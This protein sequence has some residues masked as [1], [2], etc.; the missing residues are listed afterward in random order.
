MASTVNKLK[1]TGQEPVKKNKPKPVP[2]NIEKIMSEE[3]K[4]QKNTKSQPVDDFM[5]LGDLDF[6]DHYADEKIDDKSLLL[7]ENTAPT[8]LNCGFVG[9]GGGGGKIAK[10][11]LDL[12]YNRAILVNTTAK[13]QPDEVDPDHFLLLD[14][15]D[16]VGKDVKVGEQ[17]LF[18]N[19]TLVEDTL[20]SRLGK[21]D[22]LFVC[23]SG[24]G[25]TGSSAVSLSNTFERYLSS[26]QATGKVVFIVTKPTSQELLNPTI[27]QNYNHLLEGIKSH[28]Y[29]LIDNERQLELLRGKVGMLGMYPL[30]NQAFSRMVAQVFKMASESSPIQSFDTQDLERCLSS[31]GRLF[32]GSSA[33]REF[34][35]DK[36]GLKIYQGCVERSPCPPP[37]GKP[38][39]GS[40]LLIAS[41]D[42]A[43]DPGASN[44]ME[45]AIS[46]VGGRAKTQ[47][48]GVYVRNG[49]TGLVSICLMGG[50]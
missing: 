35:D 1:A 27:S 36:L 30:A 17:V 15:S 49:V 19:C 21:V 25:G 28:P 13:D 50:M 43:N 41:P 2:A 11:F 32:L 34:K 24:G 39:V 22:W 16:G 40:L 18:E 47:F 42:T 31:P 14:G 37:S 4:E 33:V 23:A 48:S 38:E 44:Q 45:S 3:K 6:V 29:I 20:R 9:L 46:Y 5:D 12:G 26:V 10:S 7:P 8:A